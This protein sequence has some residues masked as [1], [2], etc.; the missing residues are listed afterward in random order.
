MQ[1]EEEKQL[2]KEKILKQK[3]TSGLN[4]ITEDDLNIL[5]GKKN[6]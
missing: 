2:E 4:E 5:E 6:A 3:I 1:D